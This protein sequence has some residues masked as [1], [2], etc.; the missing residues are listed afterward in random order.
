MCL[1]SHSL[2][3]VCNHALYTGILTDHLKIVVVVLLYNKRGKIS[4]T[5]YWPIL[6]LTIFAKIFE[7]ATS[8]RLNHDPHT[9]HILVIST[10]NAAFRLTDN[11]FKS[12][13]QK[14]MLEKIFCDL[15]KTS[16]YENHEIFLAK[17]HFYGIHRV[18]AAWF[19]SCLTKRE[20]KVEVK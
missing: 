3:C 15:A 12:V 20:Q 10:E 1:I 9:K 2:S 16:D 4:V 5:N 7:K 8:N 13:N 19:R 18:S 17:L 11:V 6:L 14:C